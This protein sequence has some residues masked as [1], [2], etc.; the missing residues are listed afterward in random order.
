[1]FLFLFLHPSGIVRAVIIGGGETLVPPCL[2]S[3]RELSSV[4][5]LYPLS[6]VARFMI[7]QLSSFPL[8]FF[9]REMLYFDRPYRYPVLV[10]VSPP[11]NRNGELP[12]PNH[13]LKKNIPLYCLGLVYSMGGNF[14]IDPYLP[15]LS[16]L[17]TNC[18]ANRI[19]VINPQPLTLS[20]IPS[21]QRVV[22]RTFVTLGRAG[23]FV[24][25]PFFPKGPC[26]FV[27]SSL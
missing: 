16:S 18:V 9:S 1:M 25:F 21:S 5:L 14:S 13:E 24:C 3:R 19:L 6:R 8:L 10:P 12:L 17:V 2:S 20:F 23:L 15:P 27:P 26:E 22:P 4:T 7:S 11:H